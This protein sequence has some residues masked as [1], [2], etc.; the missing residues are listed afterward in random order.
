MKDK[1]IVQM[2]DEIDYLREEL[3]KSK[4]VAMTQMTRRERLMVATQKGQVEHP[5]SIGADKL[6]FFHYWRP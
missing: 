5:D 1:L 6:P 4:E 2:Q 3:L